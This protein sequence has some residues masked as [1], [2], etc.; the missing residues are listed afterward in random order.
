MIKKSSYF[1]EPHE[2][3]LERASNGYLMSVVAIVIGLPFPIINLLATWGFY[4]MNRKSS[5]FVRWHCMQALLSQLFIAIFNIIFFYW[6]V[7]ILFGPDSVNSLYLSYGLTV[8]MMN[9]IEFTIAIVTAIYVRRG[10]HV[11]WLYFAVQADLLIK[12]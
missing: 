3:E 7:S 12:K 8:I 1:Y 6:T 4:L 10:M 9:L 11:R 2:Y 5:H